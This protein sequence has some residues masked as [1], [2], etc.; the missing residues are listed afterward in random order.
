MGAE[1]GDD[2]QG[3]CS[4]QERELRAF[5]AGSVMRHGRILGLVWRRSP[6]DF[7]W[8]QM[9]GRKSRCHCLDFDLSTQEAGATMSHNREACGRGGGQRRT[10]ERG[11]PGGRGK[12]HREGGVLLMGQGTCGWRTNIKFSG[13]GSLAT[14]TI[15]VLVAVVSQ[16][17]TPQSI[18]PNP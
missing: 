9:C 5:Q 17:T 4:I 14:L 15:L 3:L 2:S 6:Q 1:E 7:L 16:T 18:S 11:R 13:L 8:D 12:G 10:T